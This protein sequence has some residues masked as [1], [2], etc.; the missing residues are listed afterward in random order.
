MTSG[1]YSGLAVPDLVPV[2]FWEKPFLGHI[3]QV[4]LDLSGGGVVEF[5]F[6]N[7]I[8]HAGGLDFRAIE[9][10][11]HVDQSLRKRV[12]VWHLN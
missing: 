5:Q 4:L 1:D 11:T 2:P 9:R 10:E 12:P 6:G 8:F 7:F 3:Y